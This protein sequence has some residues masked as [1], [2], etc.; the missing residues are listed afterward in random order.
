MSLAIFYI[1]AALAVVSA[2]MVVTLK[3]LLHS[4]LFL[5]LTLFS[6]AGIYVLLNADFLAGVQVLI[7]V[8]AV[9]ILMIFAVMLTYRIASKSIK[10]VNEQVVPAVLI[11]LVFLALSLVMI[12]KT[13]WPLTALALPKRPIF[14]LGRQLLSTYVIPFE[15]VSLLL[16][17]ALIGVVVISVRDKQEEN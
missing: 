1:L 5:A 3:H 2:F 14:E 10:Q 17:V 15:V 12:F 16:L 8:G 9:T 4:A 11:A 7:Y 6:V 13:V